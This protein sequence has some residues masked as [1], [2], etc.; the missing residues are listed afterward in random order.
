MAQQPWGPRWLW[1]GESEVT[2]PPCYVLF[3][4]SIHSHLLPFSPYD[5]GWKTKSHISQ[6][7][8][9]IGFWMSLWLCHW[10][11]P[12]YWEGGRKA[13][14]SVSGKG[15]LSRCGCWQCASLSGQE[16]AGCKAVVDMLTELLIPSTWIPSVAVNPKAQLCPNLYSCTSS[17]FNKYSTPCI[18]S[19]C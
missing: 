10:C 17:Q 15:K 8:L 11:A 3:A 13:E 2:R 16:L 18:K 6:T 5:R 4:L 7:P 14:A 12:G 19:I 1:E 9:Q